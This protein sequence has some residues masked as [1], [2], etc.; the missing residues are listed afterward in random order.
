[1]DSPCV[2]CFTMSVF[3]SVWKEMAHLGTSISRIWSWHSQASSSC[4]SHA[5]H[6]MYYL[7]HVLA[8]AIAV[9]TSH[10]TL[11]KQGLFSHTG[12]ISSARYLPWGFSGRNPLRGGERVPALCLEKAVQFGTGSYTNGWVFF[13]CNAVLCYHEWVN[14]YVIVYSNQ[15]MVE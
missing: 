2:Q 12:W 3:L 11:S 13:P 1:M 4:Y 14:N 15:S 10:I 9:S 6:A 7:E 8:R 5:L